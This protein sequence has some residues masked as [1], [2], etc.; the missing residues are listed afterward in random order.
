[1]GYRLREI[2]GE[3]KFCQELRIE[4]LNQVVPRI[5]PR[6]VKRKMS[7]FKKKRPQPY[8]WPQP[9]VSFPEAVAVI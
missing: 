7:N 3:N 4:M 5:N 2:D 6:V 8:H 9:E 1:M